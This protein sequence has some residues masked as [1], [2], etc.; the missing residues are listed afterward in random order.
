MPPEAQAVPVP[1]PGAGV[2][3]VGEAQSKKG[4]RTGTAFDHLGGGA[5]PLGAA[6][7]LYGEPGAGKSSVAH[8]LA[9]RWCQIGGTVAWY[10]LEEDLEAVFRRA[11]RLGSHERIVMYQS[12]HAN[13]APL[14]GRHLLSIVDPI[15]GWA[16]SDPWSMVKAAEYFVE[17]QAHELGRTILALCRVD[18]KGRAAGP[19]DVAHLFDAVIELALLRP[20]EPEGPRVLRVEKNRHGPCGEW[21][22]EWPL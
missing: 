9:I 13:I 21:E 14:M 22:V 4:M 2:P 1:N 5:L 15:Q 7:L 11:E 3:L 6:S 16:G 20:G 10:V 8:K 18:K 12:S 17:Q 19:R